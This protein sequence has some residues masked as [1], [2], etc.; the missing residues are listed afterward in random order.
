MQRHQVESI[1]AR[2]L[3]DGKLDFGKYGYKAL[4]SVYDKTLQY[5]LTNIDY[6]N[7]TMQQKIDSASNAMVNFMQYTLNGGLQN[8][9]AQTRLASSY[10]LT[11]LTYKTAVSEG[12]ETGKSD[13]PENLNVNSIFYPVVA[14]HYNSC[15]STALGETG[16]NL[17]NNWPLGYEITFLKMFTQWNPKKTNYGSEI[18]TYTLDYMPSN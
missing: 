2:R 10:G 13:L 15:L 1:Y 17:T 6:A 18:L 7:L 4:Q 5:L 9:I 8:K 12:Y 14:D 11:Q 16:M 3:T